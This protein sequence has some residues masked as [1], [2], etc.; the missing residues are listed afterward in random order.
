MKNNRLISPSEA[1]L[2]A[3][4]WGYNLF[5]FAGS[6][7]I[8]RHFTHHQITTPIDDA[9][10]LIPWTI[11]IYLGCY[12]FW[13]WVYYFCIRHDRSYPHRFVISHFI[14]VSVS[15][16]TFLLFPTIMTRPEI[17]G[18]N[19]F[20]QLLKLTYWVDT[21]DTLFPSLHCFVSWLCWIGV[22]K[23]P[24]VPKWGQWTCFA[25]AVAICVSTLTVKQHVIA[26]VVSGI[27]LAEVSYWIA[28]LCEKKRRRGA[29]QTKA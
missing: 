7:Q 28:G 4:A 12:L 13:I 11:L 21:P 22:R 25:I 29:C 14:G 18:T 27:V 23:H 24:L 1:L 5:A 16:L 15:L 20:H 26:D 6:K 9:I 2:F 17:T 3:G 19:V 10:P 8:T